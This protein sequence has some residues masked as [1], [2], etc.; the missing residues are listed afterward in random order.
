MLLVSVKQLKAVETKLEERVNSQPTL[1]KGPK[2]KGTG[3]TFA[4]IGMGHQVNSELNA[5][6][7]MYERRIEELEIELSDQQREVNM[8]VGSLESM[9]KKQTFK[10]TCMGIYILN[11]V[12]SVREGLYFEWKTRSC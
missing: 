12:F 6:R 3:S 11:F 1:S 7:Q 10:L 9:L 2:L 4:C 5:E 8:Y